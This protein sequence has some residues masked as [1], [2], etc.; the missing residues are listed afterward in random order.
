MIA[1]ACRSL[2]VAVFLA[3]LTSV[4]S[5]AEPR[6]AVPRPC[7]VPPVPQKKSLPPPLGGAADPSRIFKGYRQRSIGVRTTPLGEGDGAPITLGNL[8]I[9]AIRVDFSDQEMDSTTAYFERLL[10]FQREHYGTISDGQFTLQHTLAP[11][12]YRMPQPMAWYGLDDSIGVR[13]AILC[14]DAIR[15]ADPEVNFN[16]YDQVVLFHAGPGQESDVLNDSLEQI[17]SVF[18]RMEDLVYYLPYSGVTGGIPTDDRSAEG[19]TVFVADM[20][21]FPELETQDGFVF[22]PVGVVCHELG[23]ALGLPDLYDTVAPENQVFA[24]SQGIGSWDLMAAG[25]W[26]ANGFVPA[27]FS[28][29]SKVFVGWIDPVVITAD[30]AVTLSAVEIDR[31]HG[32]VKVPLGGDEYLLIENRYQDSNGDGRFNFTENDSSKCRYEGAGPDSMLV[33]DFDFYTDSYADAEWDWWLPGEG[34]GSG[35]LIWHI[36]DSVIEENLPYNTVNAVA[37]HKGIDLEEADGIQDMDSPGQDRDS[38]GSPY[39]SYRAG[40]V[41]RFAPD[42]TPDSDAYYGIESG[43][44]VDQVSAAGARMTFRVSFGAG[45]DH[46]PVDLLAPV[47]G[48]HVAVGQLDTDSAREVV[49]ADRAGNLYVFDPDGT[50]AW[51]APDGEPFASVGV[52]LGAP[53]VADLDG[54]DVGDV[55]VPGEDGRIFGWGGPNGRPLGPL[56]DG[57]LVTSSNPIPSL[58]L[59]GADLNPS[60][61]GVEFGFGGARMPGSDL[62]RFEIYGVSLDGR[63]VRRGV[64]SLR[65]GNGQLPAVVVDIDGDG[66]QE[67]VASVRADSS[68]TTGT[69]QLHLFDPLPGTSREFVIAPLPDTAYYSAPVVGDLDRNGKMDVVIT[70]SNGNIYVLEMSVEEGLPVFHPMEGWPR[71]IFASGRDQVSLADVDNNGYLEVLALETGGVFHVFNYHG[72]SLVSLPVTVPSEQRY[73]IESQLAPLVTD[74]T[75]DGDPEFILPLDDGQVI[76]VDASG[77][78]FEEWAYFGGGQDGASPVVEDLDGDG[79][80]ELIAVSRYLDRARLDV[81]TIGRAAGPPMWSAHRGSSARPGVLLPEE[82][83]PVANGPVLDDTFAMPN[84]ARE[85]TRF[86]YRVGEGVE[87]VEIRIVDML[88]RPVRNLAGSNFTG[89][90]NTVEWDLKGA[91]GR[92]VAPGVYLARL[93]VT[94]PAGAEE[95]TMKLAVLR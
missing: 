16:D 74:L 63:P 18:F 12:V 58:E 4:T 54:D 52:P 10:L 53:L 22:S 89:T 94:G 21:M 38:F 90:D 66:H 40:W 43:V 14:W 84:P 36:D 69:V 88:G 77:R 86:H 24:E 44:T 57:V 83:L 91:D 7:M 20:P 23:H 19:D 71:Y 79:H 3:A 81:H 93:T 75:A 13:Q 35:L 70:S 27:E 62:S 82:Y 11:S 8:R 34:T 1:R 26:N 85:S 92:A 31:R 29:W 2:F 5:W 15:A 41:D 80:I 73:F 32:V 68:D 67:I 33:C 51:S 45:T 61:P 95:S 48:N 37:D 55:V 60:T 42:T 6:P 72:T 76:G 17:W 9:L 64:G 28:A 46:W 47:G 30:Q 87:S 65:G 39:D 50:G 49:V 56:H 59:F 78:Q 25:T